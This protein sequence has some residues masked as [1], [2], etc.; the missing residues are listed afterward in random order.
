MTMSS[1]Q[2]KQKLFWL[3]EEKDGGTSLLIG[4]LAVFFMVGFV[5]LAC[6]L[7][8]EGSKHAIFI[9]FVIFWATI[10]SSIGSH[11]FICAWIR[12]MVTAR[13]FAKTYLDKLGERTAIYLG[14]ASVLS[15]GAISFLGVVDGT[16]TP[17]D[18][19]FY[20][21]VAA[22]AAPLWCFLECFSE[23]LHRLIEDDKQRLAA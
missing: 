20:M 17:R 22:A 18:V 13:T 12:N 14:I 11:I 7:G 9:W 8:A 23:L 6:A 4:A 15:I 16:A 3:T 1:E 5:E 2:L 19:L 21:S 10:A